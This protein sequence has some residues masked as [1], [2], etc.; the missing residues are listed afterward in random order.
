MRTLDE[1][2]AAHPLPLFK[3]DGSP[4]ELTQMQKDDINSLALLERALGDLPV[5]Y[6]K[7]SIATCV[8][9]ML[10][11]PAT[12][13]LVPPILVA[14]WVKW[15]QS[16]PGV[17]RVVRYEGSPAKRAELVLGGARFVVASFQIFKNDFD[18]LKADLADPMTVVDECQNLKNYKSQLFK[19]VK[20]MSDG[21][22]LLLMSG[23]IMSKP[24][25]AYAYVKLN[26]PAVY[27]TYAMF[28]NVHVAKRDFFEQP[29]EWHNLDLLQDN[30]DLSRV[31]RTKEEVHA[32][33]PK[34]NYIPITYDLDP[35]HL[36]LYKK[37]M[38]EQLLEVAEG[39]IDATTAGKLYSASQQI[40]P[41]WGYFSDDESNVSKL[42]EVIDNTLEEI[43]LGQPVLPG[44]EPRS[45]LIIWSNFKRTTR[46]ILDHL[47]AIGAKASPPWRAVGAYGD[48]DS[49]AGVR[50]FMEDPAS[51]VLVAQP[52]SAGA[53]L[54][55]QAFCWEM[56]FAEMP[57]TTIPF[58]QCSGRID[59]T[60]QRYNPNIRLAV[61]RG[62]IQ[63]ALLRNLF[64]N[65]ELVNQAG[66][67]KQRIK[68]LIFPT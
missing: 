21:L 37:L 32:D 62:T 16:I 63:E 66:G 29:I 15:L 9:L 38:E 61:A 5:G 27:R 4:S 17:G 65:D 56:L 68:D 42:F 60:G 3:P 18:R 31:R 8:A 14:Q 49:K 58:V 54:N 47:N 24:G 1:V 11:Q 19:A 40:I 22:P 52:G 12:L 53:G 2:L 67:S 48:V 25:D 34:A 35:K 20:A 44:E 43:A 45:K 10:R 41:N 26:D 30:L 55:P 36:K 6:G 46:R 7:T 59:R 28:E 33:L 23:T 39:K 50:S 51:L 64:T 13:I 57:T